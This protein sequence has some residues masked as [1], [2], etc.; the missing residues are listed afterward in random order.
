MIVIDVET[1]G[2]SEHCRVLE[3]GA[4]YLELPFVASNKADRYLERPGRVIPLGA[5]RPWCAPTDRGADRI[6]VRWEPEALELARASGLLEDLAADQLEPV[7]GV[8]G[9]D[10]P[11]VVEI[12]GCELHQVDPELTEKDG[13]TWASWSGFDHLALIRSAGLSD[14]L[15]DG[16]GMYA[17]P[18]L[19]LRGLAR[20][21][22]PSLPRDTGLSGAVAALELELE[23]E[24]IA[25]TW[26]DRCR[27]W[28]PHRALYDACAAAL[29][30]L[31]VLRG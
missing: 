6:G 26:R 27:G 16:A 30:T 21:A 10:G 29:V 5:W 2:L 31:E 17:R 11:D 15:I 25:T 18:P 20:M 28:R 7:D 1:T 4:C 13:D 23:L 22:R 3:V 9:S 8:P 24:R 14:P 12:L 19:D